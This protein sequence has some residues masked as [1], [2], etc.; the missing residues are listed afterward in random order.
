MLE[1]RMLARLHNDAS[2]HGQVKE[3]EGSVASGHLTPALAVECI[4]KLLH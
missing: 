1:S 2:I 3:I 4:L